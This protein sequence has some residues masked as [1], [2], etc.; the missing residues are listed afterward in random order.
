MGSFPSDVE[1]H[2]N[3]K[4][5]SEYVLTQP[6]MFNNIKSQ[7]SDGKKVKAAYDALKKAFDVDS[8]R[9]RDKKQVYIQ[10]F[11][12]TLHVGPNFLFLL[13]TIVTA[14]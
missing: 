1:P 8:S 3:A 12:L 4:V 5:A 7:I 14:P 11:Q 2:G 10:I 6:I 13:T 9:P